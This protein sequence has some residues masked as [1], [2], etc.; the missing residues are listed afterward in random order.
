M[1]SS[2]WN[3]SLILLR[4]RVVVLTVATGQIDSESP[5]HQIWRR[6]KFSDRCLSK[7]FQN[8]EV[9]TALRGCA[10]LL[11][12]HQARGLGIVEELCDGAVLD[13]FNSFIHHEKRH[14]EPLAWQMRDAQGTDH[15]S[16][17]LTL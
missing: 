13:T 2:R 11:R 1:R 4:P 10:S 16:R 17:A 15:I 3:L 8:S 5:V 12:L 14:K 6:R 9:S 7:P